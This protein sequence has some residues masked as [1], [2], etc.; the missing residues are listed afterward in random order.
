MTPVFLAK[1]TL[2]PPKQGGREHP[3][4]GGWRGEESWFG[5]PCKFDPKD[6]TA[7][8]CRILNGLE[9]LNPGDAK[10]FGIVFLSP[11][12]APVMRKVAKFYLW[13]GKIIGEG[14]AHL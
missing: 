10:T 1:I 12:I 9:S 14:T 6:F 7:W 3:I 13:E 5:C 4:V 11:E 8:D 2:Y